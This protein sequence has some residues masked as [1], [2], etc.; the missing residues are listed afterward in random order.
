MAQPGTQHANSG[1][2][3]SAPRGQASSSTTATAAAQPPG[4]P[5]RDRHETT[6]NVD[7]PGVNYREVSRTPEGLLVG[8]VI[9]G[10]SGKGSRCCFAKTDEVNVYC[11]PDV[12]PG[13]LIGSSEIHTQTEDSDTGP[14]AQFGVFPHFAMAQPVTQH[15]NWGVANGAPARAGSPSKACGQASS[16]TTATAA[17]EAPCTT[18]GG[19]HKGIA[20]N[21]FADEG[22]GYIS[23]E[24]VDVRFDGGKS[25]ELKPGL[26]VDLEFALRRGNNAQ[27]VRRPGV[28]YRENSRTPDGLLVG[29]VINGHTGKGSGGCFAKTDE[30]N[31]YCPP[32]VSPGGLTGGSEIHI[33][34]ENS[35]QGPQAEFIR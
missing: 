30:G 19:R 10:H 20:K 29:E 13:G 4:T 22:H 18:P 8:E 7:G 12:S 6:Q 11:P 31:V 25:G 34:I 27:N 1:K 2:G 14:R 32:D 23:W 28:N 16:S 5:I 26:E 15:A 21:W 17:A 9:N 3:A 24:N 33:Q 35:G